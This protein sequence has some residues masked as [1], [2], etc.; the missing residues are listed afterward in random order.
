MVLQE[1]NMPE[2]ASVWG[3]PGDVLG[4]IRKQVDYLQNTTSKLGEKVRDIAQETIDLLLSSPVPNDIDEQ[5]RDISRALFLHLA[6]VCLNHRR[7]R[8]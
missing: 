5:K 6:S 3:M 7:S 1:A 4:R 8:A 2:W